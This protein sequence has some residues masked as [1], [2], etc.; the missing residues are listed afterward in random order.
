MS[1]A[2]PYPVKHQAYLVPKKSIFNK[3]VGDSQFELDFAAFLDG[4]NDIVSFAKNSQ[5]TF[6]RI[7][8]WQFRRRR[9]FDQAGCRRSIPGLYRLRSAG[10][11]VE[12]ESA[13]R[14]DDGPVTACVRCAPK[15]R[16]SSRWTFPKSPAFCKTALS[17]FL[18]HTQLALL[19]SDN[20]VQMC[21]VS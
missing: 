5:Q 19:A 16:G 4:C 14:N 17:E 2:R 6:L 13:P 11:L 9:Q 18:N 1:R 12:T 10:S 8:V 15:L 20:M 21:Q 3:I 7:G